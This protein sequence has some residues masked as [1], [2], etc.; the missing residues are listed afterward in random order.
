MNYK[1]TLDFLYS[2]LPIYQRTGEEAYKKDTKNI[3]IICN[4]I[5][6]PH[7][8][9]KF[10]HIGGTNG[11]G[12]TANILSEILKKQKLKIGLYT[13]PH[14]QDFRERIQINNTKIDKKFVTN[15]IQKINPIFKKI[16]P[17]FFA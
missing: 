11:K 8:K 14:Y 17:S 3:K 10:I 4:H 6:N 2:K 16:N 12:S 13:S 7:E 9:I 5:N 15:F 1:E